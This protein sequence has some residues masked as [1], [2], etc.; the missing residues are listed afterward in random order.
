MQILSPDNLMSNVLPDVATCCMQ[1]TEY[2]QQAMMH[3]CLVM[4]HVVLV[5]MSQT[6]QPDSHIVR[7]SVLPDSAAQPCKGHSKA[8][9]SDQ[10]LQIVS[11]AKEWKANYHMCHTQRNSVHHLIPP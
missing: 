9:S 6:C 3:A 7:I 4:R 8:C 5:S 10:V 1:V 2:E 11:Y